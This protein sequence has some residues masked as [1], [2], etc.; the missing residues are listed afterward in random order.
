METRVC[1][2]C[3]E[4]KD[5]SE[6]YIKK[7]GKYHSYCNGCRLKGH[8]EWRNANKKH[9]DEYK[10]KTK[11][12]RNAKDKEY[13]EQNREKLR[14]IAQIYNDSHKKEHKEYRD[15]PINKKRLKENRK[16]WLAKNRDKYN[17][18]FTKY[19]KNINHRIAHRLRTRIRKALLGVTKHFTLKSVL[20]CTLDELKLHLESQ[21]TGGMSWANYGQAEDKWNIDHIRP[22]KS[23]TDL[24]DPEQQKEAFSYRNLQP[25]WTKDNISK[26]SL[27]NGIRKHKKSQ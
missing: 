4:E 11:E 17:E 20:G 13:R 12:Y 18:Y 10:E 5:I 2:K 8:R 14:I 25:M 1:I 9:V 3:G 7:N 22:L 19:H 6:F 21:F 24:S 26:G 27:Y 15:N 23:F 16:K